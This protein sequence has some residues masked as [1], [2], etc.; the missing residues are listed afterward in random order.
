MASALPIV[1]TA[2]HIAVST[3]ITCIVTA[4]AGSAVIHQWVHWSVPD[5][6]SA[7]LIDMEGMRA[8]SDAFE[9]PGWSLSVR[10][11]AEGMWWSV[12]DPEDGVT[13]LMR[14]SLDALS[15]GPAS[16]P[17]E[18]VVGPFGQFGAGQT[19][20]GGEVGQ[21]QLGASNY[22]GFRFLSRHGDVHYGWGRMDMGDVPGS[23]TIVE[24]A[25]QDTPGFGIQVG[26][27][28]SAGLLVLLGLAALVGG[29]SGTRRRVAPS[30][31]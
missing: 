7:L 9:A 27:T 26:H 6:S 29:P 24:I 17:L 10:G 18:L 2:A 14:Y 30:P 19:A 8:S 28:P 25:W 13:G 15:S 22:F 31:R 4:H 5:G 3:A 21:W 16:V 11:G 12:C 1:P 20:F 23:G